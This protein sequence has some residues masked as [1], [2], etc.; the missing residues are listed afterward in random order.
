MSKQETE[1]KKTVNRPFSPLK[2]SP[3]IEYLAKDMPKERGFGLKKWLC[4]PEDG[5]HTMFFSEQ[6]WKE[7][8]REMMQKM[9]IEEFR[10]WADN[11]G[12]NADEVIESS[13][14][15]EQK[16]L[17]EYSSKKLKK[18]LLEANEKIKELTPY[19]WG[20]LFVEKNLSK[21]LKERMKEEEVSE[22]YFD[23]LTAKIK[24]N[25]N[26]EEERQ[27]LKIAAEVDKKGFTDEI[28]GKIKKHKEEYEWY[29]VYDY[30]LDSWTF[31]DF[32]KRIDKSKENLEKELEEERDYEQTK[33]EKEKILEEVEASENLKKLAKLAGRYS[34]LHTYRTNAHRKFY[35]N[36]KSFIEA[37]ANELNWKADLIPYCTHNELLNLL[38][39]GE[40]PTEDEVERRRQNFLLMRKKDQIE[41]FSKK[42]QI[43][44]VMRKELGREDIEV[45]SGSGVYQGKIRGSVRMVEGPEDEFFKGDVLVAK[46]TSPDLTRL[47]K[48][49]SAVVT[50]EGG[51]T[52]HAAVISKE[53]GVPCVVGTG[54]ATEKLD[55]GDWVQVDAEEGKVMKIKQELPNVY[56]QIST[57][58]GFERTYVKFNQFI[59]DSKEE[60]LFLSEG[61]E[62]PVEETMKELKKVHNKGVKIKFI[63]TKKDEENIDV[64]KKFNETWADEIRYNPQFKDYTFGVI[65]E[66]KCFQV[67]RNPRDP[68]DRF[69]IFFWNED[70]SKSLKDYFGK[71]WKESKRINFDDM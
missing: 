47:I 35:H 14:E 56:N 53:L 27:L 63:A 68:G 10:K 42:W 17:E 69:F 43:M 49:A 33:Q 1:W 41:I 52:C 55:E 36:L 60:I 64:L 30:T 37:L 23:L 12:D 70:L 40:N 31:E 44:D 4:V 66:K 26:E 7:Y 62:P 2:A 19:F 8:G 20:I 38:E 3:I 71:V 22:K 58:A 45:L 15:I 50:D 61:E 11:C 24:P 16:N 54:N 34:F 57:V 13:E 5:K 67:I 46:M 65:D 48:K 28:K 59:S 21:V 29:P 25:E 9:S 6:E 18:L 32:K 51:M 39:G